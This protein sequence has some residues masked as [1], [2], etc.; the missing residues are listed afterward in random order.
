[1]AKALGAVVGAFALGGCATFEGQI[2]PDLPT[3]LI[4][5]RVE[6]GLRDAYLTYRKD[7]PWLKDWAAT[8]ALTLKREDRVGLTPGLDYLTPINGGKFTF[9]ADAEISGRG[10][11]TLTTKRTVLLRDLPGYN[12]TQPPSEG[13]PL[14]GDLGLSAS[15]GDALR[16]RTADDVAG[17]RPD[18]L[19][20]RI[21]FGTKL[22]ASGGPTWIFRRL[23]GIG[24]GAE[25]SR[26]STSSIDF[27]FVDATPKG[28][29]RVFVTNFPAQPAQ[30][31]GPKVQGQVR[32]PQRTLQARPPQLTPDVRQQLDSVIQRLQIERLG[33]R[34]R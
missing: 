20:Y 3:D 7:Y 22:G 30:Q 16:S 9:S 25:A 5:D 34:L 10:L 8:F 13:A 27:A 1:M 17:E 11:R 18:D 14:L 24:T 29:Q 2:A 26:E 21:E 28:P 4:V 31:E 12:C 6:C 33:D 15:L 32:P 19:G 23:T